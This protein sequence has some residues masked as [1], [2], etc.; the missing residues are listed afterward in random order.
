MKQNGDTIVS[1][2]VGSEWTK[3]LLASIAEQSYKKREFFDLY[4]VSVKTDGVQKK[5]IKDPRRLTKTIEKTIEGL[6]R[7]SGFEINGIN[8]IYSPPVLKFGRRSINKKNIH[9]DGLLINKKVLES[10]KEIFIDFLEEEQRHEKCVH[11]E[12]NTII[13][14]GEDITNDPYE[15]IA[16]NSL[17]IEYSYVLVSSN[18]IDYLKDV[19]ENVVNI[20]NLQ[21]ALI[22]Y[23]D[24][25][26]EKQKE[27]GCILFD[28]GSENS[29]Y[30]AYKNNKIIDIDVLPFGGNLITNEIAL[31]KKISIHNAEELKTIISKGKGTEHITKRDI[32]SINKRIQ[33]QMKNIILPKIKPLQQEFDFPGGFLLTGGGSKYSHLIK[34][35]EKTFGIYTT[36]LKI[37]L[38]IQMNTPL[39]EECWF[40][41]YTFLRYITSQEKLITKYQN[42]RDLSLVKSFTA[43]LGWLQ[44]FFK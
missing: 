8:L 13:A 20:V 15:Y 10:Q 5:K 18:F 14:D 19:T 9:E 38:Y 32:Q 11:I 44:N 27:E 23:G 29:T 33:T 36:P 2:E 25:I 43:F 7:F 17:K 39:P 3:G 21:P 24:S 41:N 37:K 28:V 26:S 30:I 16:Y 6:E 12:T 40:A 42:K 35:F 1:L 22:A 31:F 4:G 34:L